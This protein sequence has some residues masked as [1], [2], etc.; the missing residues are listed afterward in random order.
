MIGKSLGNLRQLR[1]ILVGGELDYDFRFAF[2]M[3]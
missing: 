2:D 3:S 1:T